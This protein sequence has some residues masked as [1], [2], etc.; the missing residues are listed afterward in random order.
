MSGIDP[1]KQLAREREYFRDTIRKDRQSSAKMVEENEARHKE[2]QKNQLNE[3]VEDKT[4]LEKNFHG[5]IDNLKAKTQEAIK[6][7]ISLIK[8]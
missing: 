7:I 2:I 3:F 4:E 6:R 8:D 1:S 5:N